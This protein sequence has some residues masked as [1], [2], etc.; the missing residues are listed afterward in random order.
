M[1]SREPGDVDMTDEIRIWAIDGA[2]KA[3]EPVQPTKWTETE[4]S[5][6]GVLVRNPDMLM[7]GLK[8]VGRQTPTDSG[9]LD[10]LGV[11]E[12]GRLVVFELKREN[13]TRKAVTQAIDYCSYLESLTETELATHIA[14]RSG[15]NGIDEIKDFEEWYGERYE[16]KELTESRPPKM[17]LVGLGADAVAQRMVGFLAKSGVD[18]SLLTFHGYECGDRTLLARQIEGHES[19]E[20][21][22][23][24]RQQRRAQRRRS[25]VELAEK[26]GITDLW[27]DAVKELSV[28]DEERTRKSGITFHMRRITLDNSNA[29]GSHSLV[30]DESNRMIRV[31][32]YPAAVH[33]CWD[34]FQTIKETVQFQFETPPNAPTTSKVL[35]QWYCLLD[36]AQWETHKG[37]L[38]A[39]A[40][41]V[42]VAWRKKR[43]EARQTRR[44]AAE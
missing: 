32:F 27:Q 25:H 33:L 8:L 30:I 26:L 1:G 19:R 34:Q 10:L 40:N 43:D 9:S 17:V 13:L 5:L 2:S 42:I 22:S 35:Q 24:S 3:V 31:T 14:E 15:N 21:S 18:V 28:A 44:E 37:A 16:G 38:I 6:E 20:I 41:D 12:D 29:T 7:P 39:L 36:A 4:G 11:D 23:S